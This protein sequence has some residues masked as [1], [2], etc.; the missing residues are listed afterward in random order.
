MLNTQIVKKIVTN[1][2]TEKKKQIYLPALFKK[3]NKKRSKYSYNEY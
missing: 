1:L 2:I 3:T